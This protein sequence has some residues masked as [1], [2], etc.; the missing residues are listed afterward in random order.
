VSKK[1]KLALVANDSQAPGSAL[2]ARD[3]LNLTSIDEL[4]STERK[5]VERIVDS[6]CPKAGVLAVSKNRATWDLRPAVALGEEDGPSLIRSFGPDI[7]FAP[8]VLARTEASL[9][10][11]SKFSDLG[12]GLRDWGMTKNHLWYRRALVPQT[13]TKEFGGNFQLNEEQ[14]FSLIHELCEQ[15]SDWHSH[16]VVHG[17]IISSNIARLNNGELAL[18]DAGVASALVQSAKDVPANILKTIA[19]EILGS[20]ELE[21][22]ADVFGLGHIVKRLLLGLRKKSQFD[23]N[24][25]DIRE[26]VAG[27]DEIL[28][29]MILESN[30]DRPRL[31][32]FVAVLDSSV[33]TQPTQVEPEREEKKSSHR[34]KIVKPGKIK[35]A[36]PKKQNKPSS[37]QQIEK[38]TGLDAED[39]FSRESGKEESFSAESDLADVFED[40]TEEEGFGLQVLEEIPSMTLEEPST[41]KP[42]PHERAAGKEDSKAFGWFV[43]G[44]FGVLGVIYYFMRVAP[45]GYEMVEYNVSELRLDWQSR[46]PS[47]MITVA[48]VALDPEA[49]SKSVQDLIVASA[50]NGEQMPSVDISLLRIAFDTR[51]EVELKQ[52]DR[53][54]ALA[55]GLARL[56]GDRAPRDLGALDDRHPGVLLAIAASAGTNLNRVLGGI[57][58]STLSRLPP[59][60]GP[61]FLQISQ[62]NPEL[63]LADPIVQHLARFQARGIERADDLALYLQSDTS[64]RLQALALLFSQDNY[65]AKTIIEHLLNHPNIVL[66][67]P[68]IVWAR[69]FELTKW[70]ELEDSDKLFVLSGAP[71]S[72]GVLAQNIAKLFTHP[73]PGLRSY[74]I[75]QAV[76]RV[77]FAH[78]G[79]LAVLRAVREK[80]ELLDAEQLARLAGLLQDPENA[81]PNKIQAFMTSEPPIDLLVSLLLSTRAEKKASSLDPWIALNL[82]SRGWEPSI[83]ELRN[84]SLHPNDYTRLFA[85]NKILRL[86]DEETAKVFLET[87]LS[88]EKKPEFREQLKK[89]LAQL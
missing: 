8:E 29:Q 67:H 53:R 32:D 5:R 61:A 22:S 86:E 81:K 2:N 10:R 58:A 19:P 7:T 13:L 59:P 55:F 26:R 83:T 66:S 24:R 25:D 38:E 82:K 3:G 63:N 27:F 60:I 33:S 45:L 78:P 87:A 65:A 9:K 76:N 16:G 1:P 17:H 41:K 40:F 49:D 34:G 80:P 57:P 47:R 79:S 36:A 15:L 30:E 70:E 37:S 23:E 74:A 71:P 68:E 18:L 85:Y 56:L 4:S 44:L 35:P 54:M 46:I 31:S 39:R 11:L 69:A 43:L 62:K 42:A 64:E 50:N 72:S 20:T 28:S 21:A 6:S 73:N 77:K 88:Q 52:E 14:V 48:E 51:W 84:L 89:M 75:D 12:S